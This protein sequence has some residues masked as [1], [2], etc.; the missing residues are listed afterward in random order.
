MIRKIGILLLLL[1]SA[2]GWAG[3]VTVK[4]ARLWAAPDHT[5]VVL[6]ISGPVQHSIF[7]LTHPDRLVVDISDARLAANLSK[8][9]FSKGVVKDIRS[10]PRNRHDLRIVLDLKSAVRPKSFL[11][12]PNHTY[13]NRLVLDLEQKARAD[14]PVKTADSRPSSARDVV[15]AIDPGHGGEDPGATGP[16]GTHEKDVVLAIGRRLEALVRKTPGMRP[17]MTRDG[18]YYV[19]LRKRMEIARRNHADVFVSIH[20]DAYRGHSARGAS[21]YA[22]SQRGASSE[23]ARMLAERENASDYVGGV[24]L[25]NKSHLLASVLL[26]L[27]QTGTIEASLELG[28]DVLGQLE[29][30]GPVHR[31]RVNQAGFVV[32][33]SPD[34]PSILVETDY[35]TNPR[36]ERKLRSPRYQEKIAHAIMNGVTAFLDQNPPPGTV[37]ALREKNRRHHR[38]VR[39]DTLSGLAQRYD[40]SVRALRAANDLDGDVLHVGDVLTIPKSSES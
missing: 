38:I 25:D 27:S 21:V 37:L 33:K 4:G 16:G 23:A 19:P 24:S 11:L 22:L 13:G 9:D 1:W 10:A 34:I 15:V 26:D 7:A 29:R 14:A 30:I 32:L 5:R 20:A 8:L 12:K 28:R 40:V 3:Q 6:D 31:R 18:D 35:I 39:G 17:L 36:E 2:N